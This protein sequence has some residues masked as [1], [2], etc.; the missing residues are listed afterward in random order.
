MVKP[1]WV[2]LYTDI[3]WIALWRI[4]KNNI[5]VQYNIY[6]MVQ[7]SPEY[8]CHLN[9]EFGLWCTASS[10]KDVN[11]FIRSI[12]LKYKLNNLDINKNVVTYY[13][14][15]D[16]SIHNDAKQMSNSIQISWNKSDFDRVGW[17]F[18]NWN[19]YTNLRRLQ[20]ESYQFRIYLILLHYIFTI[21]V[22]E[23]DIRH[24]FQ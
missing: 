10:Y 16:I 23:M 7:D 8:A 5:I 24:S 20:E 6:L 1:D 12:F 22:T 17:V 19:N 21:K 13:S 11:P 4:F 15:I 3:C 9:Y 14:G 2:C 18:I